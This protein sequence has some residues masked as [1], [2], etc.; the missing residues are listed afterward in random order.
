VSVRLFAAVEIPDPE[1]EGLGQWIG[2]SALEK[3]GL[4]AVKPEQWHLTLAFYGEVDESKVDD[5]EQRLARAAERTPPF[6]LRLSGA[7]TFPPDPACAR[8]LWVAVDGDRQILDR[9]SD[10]CRAAGRRIGLRLAAERFRPH[11]TIARARSGPVDVRRRVDALTSYTGQ[12]WQVTSFRLIRST[13]GSTVHHE[14]ISE[15]DLS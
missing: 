4:R 2:D 11:L 1:L 8:V 15:F 12:P 13:L 9:L 7:G 14:M 6:E 3:S 10:R 5:L